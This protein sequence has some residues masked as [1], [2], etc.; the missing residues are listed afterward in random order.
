MA[1]FIF[2][3]DSQERQKALNEYLQLKDGFSNTPEKSKILLII[4]DIIMKYLGDS[5]SLK[6]VFYGGFV[7]FLRNLPDNTDSRDVEVHKMLNTSDID[8]Y[9]PQDYH[10]ANILVDKLRMFFGAQNVRLSNRNSHRGY[11]IGIFGIPFIDITK[12]SNEYL[13]AATPICEWNHVPILS[14]ESYVT[15]AEQLC[16]LFRCTTNSDCYMFTD[17]HHFF[18]K[19]LKGIKE[20]CPSSYIVNSNFYKNEY[21]KTNSIVP[22]IAFSTVLFDSSVKQCDD[23]IILCG[24]FA[25]ALF[26]KNAVNNKLLEKRDLNSFCAIAGI[27]TDVGTFNK[28]NTE[29]SVFVKKIKPTANHGTVTSLVSKH[30]KHKTQIL[31]HIYSAK[32]ASVPLIKITEKIYIPGILN[33][34]VY[35]VERYLQNPTIQN[36][37][38]VDI[39][40]QCLSLLKSDLLNEDS[41]VTPNTNIFGSL[42]FVCLD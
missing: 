15:L 13:N 32:F 19:T 3:Y 22:D 18:K 28:D 11:K 39:L 27:N 35:A 21:I 2:A 26:I 16:I 14:M 33:L 41:S 24:N 20:C 40:L 5:L 23:S 17:R 1:K 6:C 37:F 10:L 38:A 30:S 25:V 34:Y 7:R 29:I 8:I 12:C 9:A 4:A 31:Y 42:Q 36:F